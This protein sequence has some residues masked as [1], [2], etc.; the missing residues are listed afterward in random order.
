MSVNVLMR[1]AN[2]FF[3]TSS[4]LLIH[5]LSCEMKINDSK[6]SGILASSLACFLASYFE[7]CRW[8]SGADWNFI[9]LS[10]SPIH[11]LL[12]TTIIFC[13]VCA[14]GNRVWLKLIGIATKVDQES[15]RDIEWDG[16][17]RKG[18]GIKEPLIWNQARIK[19]CL[20]KQTRVIKR[21]QSSPCVR[22]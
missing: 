11:V 18:E 21:R 19:F 20:S 16:K 12:S 10:L 3:P 4:S 8:L 2:N 13:Y 14:F 22:I 17:E 5:H 9:S 15:S 6:W 7:V 1:A